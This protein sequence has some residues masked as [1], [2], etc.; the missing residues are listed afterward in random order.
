MAARL[1]TEAG[2]LKAS[3]LAAGTGTGRA[4]FA[5]ALG[6]DAAVRRDAASVLDAGG[7]LRMETGS[8][9]ARAG[10]ALLRIGPGAASAFTTGGVFER[11]GGAT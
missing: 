6:G 11:V 8:A 7:V 2:T 5:S 1:E 3:V 4:E 9:S 10:A